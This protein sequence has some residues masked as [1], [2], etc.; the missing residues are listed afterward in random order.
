MVRVVEGVN[1]IAGLSEQMGVPALT[2]RHVKNPRAV[3]E[4][5][6]LDNTSRFGA[7]ALEREDWL[8]L[9][10]IPGIEIR[11]PPFL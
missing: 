7:V 5:K 10:E 1:L 4:A 3:M 2:A 6:H 8:I 9:E 11:L